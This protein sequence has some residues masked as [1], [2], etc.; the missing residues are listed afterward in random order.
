MTWW[1]TGLFPL[2]IYFSRRTGFLRK[3]TSLDYTDLSK[4]LGSPAGYCPTR[5]PALDET[6]WWI[7]KVLT[8]PGVTNGEETVRKCYRGIEQGRRA[9]IARQ[10][11]DPTEYDGMIDTDGEF[12]PRWNN[13]LVLSSSRIEELAVVHLLIF[14]KHPAGTPSG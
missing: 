4:F 7:G 2:Q 12:D 10:S 1:K 6:E 11:P 14:K 13:G 3:D 8:G 5:T 9:I